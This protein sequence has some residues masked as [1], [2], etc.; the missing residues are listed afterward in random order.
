M[1]SEAWVSNLILHTLVDTGLLGLVIQVSL[2]VLVAGRTW[3]AARVTSDPRLEVGLKAMT[4]GF[5]VMLIAYQ[6]TDGTWL[7][8]F[9]I[10]LGLMVNGIYCVQEE[11][12]RI[13]SGRRA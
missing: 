5:L 7:A 3:H 9:W 8:V 10:H 4:L 11:Q 12:R 6:I 2:F 1:G 13:A